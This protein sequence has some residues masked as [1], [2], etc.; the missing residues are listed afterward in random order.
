[1]P[2]EIQAVILFA[3]QQ[4]MQWRP[5]KRKEPDATLDVALVG[6]VGETRFKVPTEIFSRLHLGYTCANC[7]SVMLGFSMFQGANKPAMAVDV[8]VMD[9]LL[10]PEPKSN[11]CSK[12]ERSYLALNHL[13][14][15]LNSTQLL[16]RR[17][18]VKG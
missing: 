5:P 16:F 6:R 17:F 3:V 2:R 11:K 12:L 1:M 7:I 9:S 15:F 18:E 4:A 8:A 13:Q 14:W 10:E